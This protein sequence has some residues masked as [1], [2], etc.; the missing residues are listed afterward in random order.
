MD[1]RALVFVGSVL[2][3]IVWIA[4]LSAILWTTPEGNFGAA[5]LLALHTRVP[6]YPFTIQNLMWIIFFIGFGELLARY[7]FGGG[8][9]EQLSLRLLP[10]DRKSMLR[11][12]DLGPVYEKIDRSDP[13][14]RYWLQ[15][16]LK[17]AILQFQSSGSIGQVISMF[18]SLL[19]L[20]Q[21]EIE[22]RY[23]LLRY[24]VW[25]IPTLGFIGTVV[26]I[27]LALGEA[28]EF[29]AA[30]GAGT[31]TQPELM[32]NLTRELGVAFYHDAAGVVAVGRAD[33]DYAR[34][35]RPGRGCPQ[36]GRPVLSTEL[37]ESVV[38]TLGRFLVGGAG[39]GRRARRGSIQGRSTECLCNGARTTSRS[40]YRPR[41][42][43]DRRKWPGS[44]TGVPPIPK[45]HRQLPSPTGRT[46]NFIA[47]R[48][49]WK[50][51][52]PAGW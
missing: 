2:A 8:E 30:A 43:R 46:R 9:R 4:V 3:G 27:A 14:E 11:R 39:G 45:S 34:R 44:T 50:I 10:E 33:G 31:G 25:L 40:M 26:G 28:G 47:M 7:L 35:T 19:E 6:P 20:Y 48:M 15:R 22:L 21:H 5:L 36:P 23:N 13:G 51:R 52:L 29:F 12:E 41:W 37:G 18:D 17:S 38:R 16:L 24:L 42:S 32:G 1:N 49:R